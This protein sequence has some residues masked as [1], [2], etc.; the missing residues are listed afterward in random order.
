MHV[1]GC[2]GKLENDEENGRN[3]KKGFR[4][5]CYTRTVAN[6]EPCSI[7]DFGIDVKIFVPAD[8]GVCKQWC[9]IIN[10]YVS[11]GSFLLFYKLKIFILFTY[12]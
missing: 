8:L 2:L 4:Y 7:A 1:G 3:N 6:L 11:L 10:I 12:L 5:V 9:I